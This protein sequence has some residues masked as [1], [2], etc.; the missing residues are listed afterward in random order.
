MSAPPVDDIDYLLIGHFTADLTPRG[1]QLGGTVSYAAKTIQSF[2]LQVGIVSSMMADDPLFSAFSETIQI[3]RVPAEQTTTFENIYTDDGRKQYVRGRAS[4]LIESQIPEQWRS[5]SLV[6]FGPLVNEVDPA[7]VR[8]F[9]GSITLLTL[10]GLLREWGNDGLVRFKR[11]F[12]PEV[13]AELDFIVF[14]EE[15]ILADPQLEQDI[16]SIAPCLIVTRAEKG[17]TIYRRGA[18]PVNY[19]SPHVEVVQPTGAGDVFAASLLAAYH[20]LD[21]NLP[22]AIDVAA[23]LA[24]ICVTRDGLLGVPTSAEVKSTIAQVLNKS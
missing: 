17:G 2:G 22:K 9:P 5:A 3:H 10:Q 7:L 13:I 1:R 20:Q 21:G 4:D 11:W 15:D 16:A 18:L 12:V 8:L 6:H 19:A 23:E 24:A 14:S